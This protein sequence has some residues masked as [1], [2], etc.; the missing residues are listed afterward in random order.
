[1]VDISGTAVMWWSVGLH[2]VVYWTMQAVLECCYIY[3][4]TSLVTCAVLQTLLVSP[5]MNM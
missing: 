3:F 5:S 4:I 2:A 1:M